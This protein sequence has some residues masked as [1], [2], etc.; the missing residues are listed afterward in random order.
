MKD[1]LKFKIE[2]YSYDIE[3]TFNAENSEH[4]FVATE[5][6]QDQKISITVSNE[7]GS[8]TDSKFLQC[9]THECNH[10]AMCILGLNG[11]Y[12]NYHNQEALCYLQDF[13]FRKCY[14]FSLKNIG[15]E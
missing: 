15:K 14:E 3:F 12:F 6:P 1:K 13:I 11:V 2:I 4:K 7:W 9:L 5:H 8:A 10:A